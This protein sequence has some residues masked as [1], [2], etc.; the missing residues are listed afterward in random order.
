MAAPEPILTPLPVP[1][2]DDAHT[3]DRLT[4]PDPE[5]TG[6]F[7]PPATESAVPPKDAVPGYELREP[8]GKGGMGVVY[9][10]RQVGLN[11][12][13]AL[14]MV[15]GGHRAEPRELIR[16]L[17]E[18][19]AVA[20]VKHPHVVQ[21]H[22]Y[23]EAD[24]RPFLAMEYLPGGSLADRLKAHGRLD[25]IAAA[26]LVGTLAGAVQAAHDQGIVHRDLK[27][28]NVLFDEAGA[29]K[30]TDFGMAKRR[31]GS[32]L[33][34]TQAVMG[35]PAYM[36]PEQ[37]RGDTKF[38]GPGADV[39]A[40]GVILYECLTGTRPFAAS[41]ALSL[42]RKVAEEEPER[43]GKRLP[44]LPRDVELV[45]LKCLAKEPAERYLSAAALADDLARYAAGEPVS[46]R[47]AGLLERGYKWARRKP[48]LAASYGLTLAV[49]VLLGFGA[50]LA[51]LWRAAESAK[52]LAEVAQGQAESARDGEKVARAEAEG[53]REKFAR[54]EY[55]RSMHVAHQEWRENNV[56]TT[57]ALLDQTRSDLRGW[58]WH[59]LK[60]L[61]HSDLLTLKGHTHPV[62][63]AS[64]SRDGS[65]IV[66]GGWDGTARVWDAKTGAEVL[67]LKGHTAQVRSASFGP[68]GSRIV[69][70]S[71][72]KTARVWDA[73]SGAE[74]L[75]L[76]GH[77]TY[78]WSASFSPDGL[79]IVTASADKSARVWD[80]RTGGE[81][82]VLREFMPKEVHQ[83]SR[84]GE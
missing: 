68:D 35:T 22:E 17:A 44:R 1:A 30:V 12:I 84:M 39:Y 66:T 41:D 70:A 59:Y 80:A 34:A 36:A 60:R 57:L 28:A 82:L 3:H 21:V 4:I 26:R 62:G 42:L 71:A 65:R 67:T 63:S 50:S 11:R 53:E 79:R 58:E 56:P 37:A 13:V 29:P 61:C 47:A 16:F 19:E 54:F 51:A 76:R 74:V 15:L 9:K 18:A 52:E 55:G 14:K 23:G 32:D 64:F 2:A 10:A 69:T 7:A 75:A 5:V 20:A 48:T 40:L 27:P 77:S 81:F 38:V 31:G 33:T 24:G 45:C 46:V 25:P 6:P 83:P 73:K 72:D 8:L 49:L 78:V 43:P